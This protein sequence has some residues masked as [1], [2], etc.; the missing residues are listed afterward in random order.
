MRTLLVSASLLIASAAT[1]DDNPRRRVAVLE[2]R[3]GS[4]ALV[5]L[6]AQLASELGKQT[7][8]DVLGPAQARAIY[9]DPLDGAVVKCGGEAECVARIG[10]R[11][12]AAEVILIGV[13]ELGDVILTMQR[14]DVRTHAVGAR[15]ADSFAEGSTPT[16]EQVAKY[17][18]RLLPPSDFL[19]FGVIAIVASQAGA[20]V[21]V[22]GQT[23][24]VTPI[25][26]LKLRAPDS[27]AIRIEKEGFLPF[28]T[29]VQLPPD[30][31]LRVEA[32]LARRSARAWYQRWWAVSGLGLLIAGAAATT[33]YVVTRDDE[34]RLTGSVE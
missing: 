27:Y 8:L 11:L 6:G 12:A 7:S 26:P 18:G 32:E 1:A 22:S 19:R 29:R 23:R 14:I 31:E 30:G 2:Y 34:L 21:S 24:G 33:I 4:S 10:Q 13:S 20:R 5:G 16:G 17:L 28:S 9:G 25:A 15:I 3:A